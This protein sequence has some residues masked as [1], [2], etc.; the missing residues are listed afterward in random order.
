MIPIDII[1]RKRLDH[2]VY[3]NGRVKRAKEILARGDYEGFGRLLSES[4][5]S[6][7]DK[8]KVTCQEVEAHGQSQS[9]ELTLPALSI[10]VFK[11][12]APFVEE[13]PEAESLSS[14]PAA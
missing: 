7:A 9:A 2:V 6:L 13:I 1:T 4:H 12:E 11:P 3:E 5:D 14:E 8:L 10:I